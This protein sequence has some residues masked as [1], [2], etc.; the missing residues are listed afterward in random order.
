MARGPTPIPIFWGLAR[1][2]SFQIQIPRI[3]GLV[4]QH[5][6]EEVVIDEAFEASRAEL[7]RQAQEWAGLDQNPSANLLVFVG[8][9]NSWKC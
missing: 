4:G 7:K 9:R 6:Q 2:A 3:Q 8:K 1:L 5:D